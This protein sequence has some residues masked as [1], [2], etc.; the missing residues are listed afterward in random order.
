MW[1]LVVFFHQEVEVSKVCRVP[2]DQPAIGARAQLGGPRNA[3]L[4]HA[5]ASGDES[6]QGRFEMASPNLAQFYGLNPYWNA[7]SSWILE[8]TSTTILGVGAR[9]AFVGLQN[10]GTPKI[11]LL[12]CF[13]GF[14][15]KTNAP[16]SSVTRTQVSVSCS[17]LRSLDGRIFW[18][19]W[20]LLF[21]R[22]D[23]WLLHHRAPLDPKA[24]WHMT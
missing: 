23:Q 13:W 5:S 17:S 20:R 24:G 4:P 1:F 19:G 22:L 10:G 11:S 7:W 2:G 21:S 14:G 3:G 16:N 6:E 18:S 15:A 8:A 9:N 12:D